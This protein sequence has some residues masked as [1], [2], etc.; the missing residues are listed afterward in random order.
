MNVMRNRNNQNSGV[1]LKSEEEAGR[2][3]VSQEEGG[4]HHVRPNTD[5]SLWLCKNRGQPEFGLNAAFVP[6]R[7]SLPRRL[8]SVS[9]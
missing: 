9:L 4:D 7:R 5:P 6:G 1:E 2:Q 8:I 3:F